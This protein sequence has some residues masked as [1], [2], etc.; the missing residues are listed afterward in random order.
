MTPC[1]QQR[2]AREAD[3][4]LLSCAQGCGIGQGAG[5]SS[6]GRDIT[7]DVG[8]RVEDAAGVKGVGTIITGAEALPRE[9]LLVRSSRL[10]Q[11]LTQLLYGTQFI[12]RA[13]LLLCAGTTEGATRP[14]RP[15]REASTTWSCTARRCATRRP[16]AQTV[17]RACRRPRVAE[18]QRRFFPTTGSS[19]FAKASLVAR[20]PAPEHARAAWIKRLKRATHR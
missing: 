1:F 10:S 18:A 14:L 16:T 9:H 2:D 7:P 17:R 19:R 12:L 13:A 15:A 8:M 20:T 4:R 11:K 3:C 5:M 6:V